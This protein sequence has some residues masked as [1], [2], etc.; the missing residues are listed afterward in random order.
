MLVNDGNNATVTQETKKVICVIQFL[1]WS[2]KKK[3]VKGQ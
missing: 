2:K 3:V 1:M